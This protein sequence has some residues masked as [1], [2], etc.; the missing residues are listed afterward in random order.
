MTF[1]LRYR[2]YFDKYFFASRE[3][4]RVNGSL[5]SAST[6]SGNGAAVRR[7]SAAKKLQ[8]STGS[9]T[10]PCSSS[11][12]RRRSSAGVA[13]A[14]TCSEFLHTA[15]TAAGSA[16]TGCGPLSSATGTN[17]SSQRLTEPSPASFSSYLPDAARH[18]S[19]VAATTNQPTAKKQRASS[20][21]SGGGPQRP[22]AAVAQKRKRSSV[23]LVTSIQN[24]G[25]SIVDLGK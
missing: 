15:G 25:P 3:C 10:L 16:E 22:T 19:A 18:G 24:N 21:N 14:A 2:Y 9:S 1:L 6:S 12:A 5:L 11:A 17:E 13:F 20:S 7:R 4:W 8:H 23:V